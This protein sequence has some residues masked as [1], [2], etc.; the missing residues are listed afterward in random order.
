MSV[1]LFCMPKRESVCK[2]C[3]LQPPSDVSSL[4]F[5]PGGLYFAQMDA[6]MNHTVNVPYL[7]HP[8]VMFC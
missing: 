4:S 7:I 6:E 2:T 8:F 5:C 1:I 3:R